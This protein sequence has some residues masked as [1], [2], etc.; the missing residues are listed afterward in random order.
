MRNLKKQGNM[1]LCQEEK[2]GNRDRLR[3]GQILELSDKYY[4]NL[5]IINIL[6]N[7]VETVH[8][9][10]GKGKVMGIT[11]KR[12]KIKMLDIRNIISKVKNFLYRLN[13][14]NI[15]GEIMWAWGQVNGNDPNRNKEKKRVRINSASE[16]CGDTMKPSSVHV[17]I[18][19]E[20]E[21]RENGAKEIYECTLAK[22]FSKL[23]KCISQ[24][25][26]IFK[27]HLLG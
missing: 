9:M 6:K 21:K 7:L 10:H 18:T 19:P 4:D 20:G 25:S 13:M 16:I 2:K 11:K 17:I 1:M 24:I 12:K 5:T 3:D 15:A 27:K 23:I 8:N 26:K 22:F 14:L